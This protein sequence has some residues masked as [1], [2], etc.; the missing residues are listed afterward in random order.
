MHKIASTSRL[1]IE[2]QSVKY[3]SSK[4]KSRVVAILWKVHIK[5]IILSF[6]L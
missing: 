3:W 2:I 5:L 1:V 4:N 6:I